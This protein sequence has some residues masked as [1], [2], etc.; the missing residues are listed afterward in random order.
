[1]AFHFRAVC[2]GFAT[3]TMSSPTQLDGSGDADVVDM[4]EV[5]EEEAAA[6]AAAGMQ[7]GPRGHK[8]TPAAVHAELLALKKK[9][10]AEWWQWLDPVLVK[11]PGDSPWGRAIH[12]HEQARA[13]ARQE[14]GLHQEQQLRCRGGAG[15]A[16]CGGGAAVCRGLTR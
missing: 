16:H 15:Q 8:A 5:E 1:L 14:A 4:E 3:P 12:H 9:S 10:K 13:G 11:K 6:A 7:L 2:D